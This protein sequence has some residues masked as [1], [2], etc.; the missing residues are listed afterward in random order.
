[1]TCDSGNNLLEYCAERLAIYLCI[2]SRWWKQ[3]TFNDVTQ[4]CACCGRDRTL[5]AKSVGRG[6]ILL[7]L[8]HMLAAAGAG[9]GSQVFTAS[10]LI[11]LRLIR[12]TVA[13]AA[14]LVRATGL[15][16]SIIYIYI[17]AV[18]YGL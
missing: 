8:G 9:N 15:Y 2:T 11:V 16:A 17:L 5:T 4:F 3:R 14:G 6:K 10:M 12:L 18:Y 13:L 7:L 1:M